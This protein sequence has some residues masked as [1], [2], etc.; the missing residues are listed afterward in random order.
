MQLWEKI[1]VP[2]TNQSWQVSIS[3]WET[4]DT[5]SG[6]NG[7]LLIISRH[8]GAGLQTATRGDGATDTEIAVFLKTSQG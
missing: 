3:S 7:Q 6:F 5:V 1:Y 2:L 4:G 8:C